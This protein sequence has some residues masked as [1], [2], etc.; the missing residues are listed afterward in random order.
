MFNSETHLKTKLAHRII[1]SHTI[2]HILCRKINKSLSFTVVRSE[3]MP[4]VNMYSFPLVQISN[5]T[6]TN[7]PHPI[8][9]WEEKTLSLPNREYHHTSILL[10]PEVSLSQIVDLLIHL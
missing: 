3:A 7:G 2:P 6:H 5:H 4:Y 1:Y 9:E 8:E 10:Y